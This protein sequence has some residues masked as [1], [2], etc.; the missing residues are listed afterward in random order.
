MRLDFR[1]EFVGDSKLPVI[2]YLLVHNNLHLVLLVII[3]N[4]QS[5]EYCTR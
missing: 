1:S 4:F 2:M 3:F 5:S